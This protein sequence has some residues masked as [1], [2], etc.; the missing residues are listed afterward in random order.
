MRFRLTK[1]LF[2][3]LALML[4]GFILKAQQ[5][6]YSQLVSVIS[7]RLPAADV[8][9]KIISFTAWSAADVQGRDMNKE[10]DRVAT[11]YQGAKLRNGNRGTILISCNLDS[12]TSSAIAF[13]RDGI[14]FAIQVNKSDFNFLAGCSSNSNVVYDATGTKVYENLSKGDVFMS[15]NQLITR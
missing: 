10:F 6:S 13:H 12:P 14:S 1:K 3:A 8:S 15:Y 11:I 7:S 9:G 2:M 5:P 4:S